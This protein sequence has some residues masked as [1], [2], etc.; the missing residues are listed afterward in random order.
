MQLC[1]TLS[2]VQKR[3]VE[4]DPCN[5]EHLE[6]YRMLCIGEKDD[7]GMIHVQQHPTLR[8][9]TETPF[10]EVPA[11]MAYRVGEKYL[12]LMVPAKEKGNG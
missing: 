5:P 2:K 11:M 10:E 7:R 3:F 1:S 8:F 4:F 12:D 9:T 6:A